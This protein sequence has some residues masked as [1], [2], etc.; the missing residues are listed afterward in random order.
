MVEWKLDPGQT[1]HGCVCEGDREIEIHGEM[2]AEGAEKR[3]ERNAEEG[4]RQGWALVLVWA[5]LWARRW[6]L[7]VAGFGLAAG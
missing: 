2:N 1:E 5:A 3:R 7:C 6:S 4:G